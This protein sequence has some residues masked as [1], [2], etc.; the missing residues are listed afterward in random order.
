MRRIGSRIIWLSFA[1]IE[2]AIVGWDG[3]PASGA[4]SKLGFHPGLPLS[5]GTG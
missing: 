2:N 1:A 4:A 5:I 3:I